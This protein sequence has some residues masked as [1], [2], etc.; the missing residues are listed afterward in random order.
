MI[1]YINIFIQNV[2]N[3]IL[4]LKYHYHYSS[5]FK[6]EI[7][8]LNYAFKRINFIS[9]LNKPSVFILKIY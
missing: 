3:K 7:S 6:E 4:F 9:Y 8:F 1:K 5:L 2:K